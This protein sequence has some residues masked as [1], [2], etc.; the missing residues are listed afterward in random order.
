M[1]II[2]TGGAG[3]IGSH[4][5]ELLVNLGHSIIIIDNLSTGYKE[6]LSQIIDD[7]FFVNEDIELCDLSSFSGVDVIVHLAAQTS[8]PLSVENFKESSS[9][10]L[11]SNLNVIN[12]C[13][14]N[15]IAFVYASSSAIYGNLELGDDNS[16]NIDLISPYSVDKYSMELYSEMAHKIYGLSSIGLRFFNVYGPRQDPTSP[17]SGVISI[18]IDKL[19]SDEKV[20]VNG[21]Y[22]TRDFIF[23][24]DVVKMIE[25]SINISSKNDVCEVVNV[26]T[27]VTYSINSLL[28]ML[29][30]LLIRKPVVIRRKLSAG[31]PKKS[32][33]TLDKMRHIFKINQNSFIGFKDGLNK[34]IKFMCHE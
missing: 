7:V 4:L 13:S 15:K 21:G 20:L 25:K 19:A 31:D 18:F 16:K 26:L 30:D 27:G 17:Y 9:V 5:A 8:V 12:Y 2:I 14:Q 1:K 3:F 11:L 10:N 23:V 34:T 33:G 22:Q 6:N 29:A 24:T 28:E 32:D